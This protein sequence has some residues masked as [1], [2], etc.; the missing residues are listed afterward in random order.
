M[1]ER[2]ALEVLAV[3]G[4]KYQNVSRSSRV[5]TYG[6]DLFILFRN[7]KTW[8]AAAN[9]VIFFCLYKQFFPQIGTSCMHLVIWLV[10]LSG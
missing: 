9:I 4:E 2:T 5:S 3:K 6:Q 10:Q 8:R 7:R 1:K